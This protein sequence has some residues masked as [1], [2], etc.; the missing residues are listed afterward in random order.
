[1]RKNRAF[2]LIKVREL[3]NIKQKNF[4]S[5]FS[6]ILNFDFFFFLFFIYRNNHS[7]L[8]NNAVCYYIYWQD[9]LFKL[10]RNNTIVDVGNWYGPGNITARDSTAV[11]GRGG[12]PT[13]KCSEDC[14][15]G[16]FRLIGS[17]SCCWTCPTCPSNTISTGI[18]VENFE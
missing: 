7:F 1:M 13:G 17:S 9:Y 18:Q 8:E 2:P 12:K 4:F 10:Y 14:G 16:S 3:T 11:W 5:G 6:Y 15:P